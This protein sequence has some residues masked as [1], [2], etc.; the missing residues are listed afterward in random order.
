MTKTVSFQFETREQHRW[1][2]D[3]LDRQ[4]TPGPVPLTSL[5]EFDE[6]LTNSRIFNGAARH[7]AQSA[8][9]D[10]T[11]ELGEINSVVSGSDPGRWGR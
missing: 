3:S 4:S 10:F 2:G 6:Y 1:P 5:A 9:G 8:S 11:I 7:K